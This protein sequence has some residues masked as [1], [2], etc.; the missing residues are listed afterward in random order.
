MSLPRVTTKA[1]PNVD[2]VKA[3]PAYG[4][5]ALPKINREINHEDLHTRQKALNL[6]S[7]MLHSPNNIVEAI[8]VGIVKSLKLVI[9]D[10]DDHVRVKSTEN[11]SI[12][13]GHAK[14]REA[15]LAINVIEPL[16]S[17]FEDKV[18]QVR[19]SVHSVLE[20]LT[21][22]GEGAM[23][24]IDCGLIPRFV[25]RLEFEENS[26]KELI[27]GSLHNCMTR[28]TVDALGCSAMTT[29]VSL[30]KHESPKIR[31]KAARGIMALTFPLKGKECAVSENAIPDLVELLDDSSHVV[32]ANACGALMSITITTQG[33]KETLKW[34][35]IPKLVPLIC[36]PTPEVQLNA[37]KALTTLSEHPSGRESLSDTVDKLTDISARSSDEYIRRA[38]EVAV[39]TITWK[40]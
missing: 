37:I 5:C 11:M 23:Y 38:A 10:T 30:L 2:P 4:I 1:P 7:D 25:E 20:T 33:K 19:Y 8:R 14:G 13:S 40:P 18:Y 16:S 39:K 12:L 26:V 27:L 17:L 29:L 22:S 9:K 31:G 24:A 35:V 15:L 28:D 32:R 6:L 36:D 3:S 34:G 21:C